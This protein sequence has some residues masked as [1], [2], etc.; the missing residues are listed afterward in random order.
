MVFRCGKVEYVQ[1][2]V[3]ITL[4]V[5]DPCVESPAW[6]E[7][8]HSYEVELHTHT[9]CLPLLSVSVLEVQGK[10][11]WQCWPVCPCSSGILP[12]HCDSHSLVARYRQEQYT[13]IKE[14][15]QAMRFV[16][17]GTTHTELYLRMHQLENQQLP[18]RSDLTQL[19][20]TYSYTQRKLNYAL[21]HYA[22][23]HYARKS[24]FPQ[25]TKCYKGMI[26][27]WKR[28]GML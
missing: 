1:S 18:C 19:V 10:W 24:F 25:R 7:Q 14:A 11:F 13:D 23:W 4:H 2:E 27:R 12:P 15:L 3:S 17:A 26:W 16:H 5:Q 22:F 8:S 6:W 20:R 28:F 21:W 9:F